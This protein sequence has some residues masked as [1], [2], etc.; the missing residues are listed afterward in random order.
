MESMTQ[1]SQNHQ[2][3][4]QWIGDWHQIKSIENIDLDNSS[5]KNITHPFIGFNPNPPHQDNPVDQYEQL[6]PPKMNLSQSLRSNGLLQVLP[7]STSVSID[8][9]SSYLPDSVNDEAI[10]KMTVRQIVETSTPVGWEKVFLDSETEYEYIDQFLQVQEQIYG[11]CIPDRK[12]LFNAFHYC[13]LQNV[14]V[15]IMGQDPYHTIRNG[16]PIAHGLSFSTRQELKIVPPSLRNI[17][18]EISRTHPYFQTPDHGDLTNWARQGVLLLNNCL[19]VNKNE[20]K[21]HPPKLWHGF[22]TRV[23]QAIQ[24]ANPRCIFVLWGKEAKTM[25]EKYISSKARVLTSSHPSPMSARRGFNK[26]DHFLSINQYLAEDGEAQINW[27]V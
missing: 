24:Q 8:D 19:T 23:F 21:S 11:K 16:K 6:F 22:L 7:S 3:S 27:Q 2:P 4:N 12:D 9:I 17:Y 26:C 15:V 10:E 5:L 18:K 14:K 13:P 25:T 20:A 1:Y